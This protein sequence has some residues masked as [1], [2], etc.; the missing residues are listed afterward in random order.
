MD[1]K[2]RQNGRQPLAFFL[3]S[4]RK[5]M[6]HKLKR[7]QFDIM[8]PLFDA[9]KREN[10]PSTQRL[11][12]LGLFRFV[13]GDGVCFPSYSALMDETGLSRQSIANTIKK[14]SESGWLT[15]E[16]GDKSKSLANTYYLNLERLGLT[17][18]S[19]IVPIEGYIA[20]DG[21]KWSCAAD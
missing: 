12:L 6:T 19:K 8:H 5:I 4:I 3:V 14:L 13:D 20:Q 17:T 15:Y 1:K 11:L 2:K 7:S 18:Q 10:L 21:T 9:M 16:P